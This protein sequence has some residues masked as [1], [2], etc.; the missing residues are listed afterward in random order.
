MH[1]PTPAPPALFGRERELA[2]LRDHLTAALN[3]SGSLVLIGG[4]AGIGKTVLAE[5]LC[6]EATEQGALVL[7]GHCYDLTE[8]PPYGPWVDLFAHYRPTDD[9]PPPP[10]PFA[11]R[12]T[13]GAVASQAT[14]Y[15]AI[16]DFLSTVAAQRPLVIL[17]EDA[18]WQDSASLDLLRFLAREVASQ[19]LLLLVT[20]RSDEL[21]RR[22]SLYPPLPTLVREASAARIVVR[23]LDATDTGALVRARFLLPQANATRLISYLDRRGEGNPF[24]I[25]ELLQALI[26]EEVL[27]HEGDGWVLGDLTGA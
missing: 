24:F 6:G 11:E 8:T 22:H 27:R 9:L 17:L 23:P 1:A 2:L 13:V 3:G 14:L 19:P 10:A 16:L 15:H 4:E 5:A 26:E 20:Y 18:H 25:G 12:G 21:T 7:T